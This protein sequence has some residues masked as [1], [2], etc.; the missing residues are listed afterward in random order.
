MGVPPMSAEH[1]QDERSKHI[2]LQ[3]RVVAGVA[4]RAIL[5]PLIEQSA[6]LEKLDKECHLT[7]ATY[8]RSWHPLDVNFSRE[9]I[10]AGSL[11]LRQISGDF[12]LT[13]WVS[14]NNSVF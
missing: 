10:E 2:A 3:R 13:R 12:Y 4:K 8:R 6:G 5:Y 9:S 11:A 7:E 1:R 14:L